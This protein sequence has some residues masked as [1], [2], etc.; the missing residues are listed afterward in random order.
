MSI[1]LHLNNKNTKKTHPNKP[2]I[3]YV[4][5][6]YDTKRAN[7]KESQVMTKSMSARVCAEYKK[8][9]CYMI[10]RICIIHMRLTISPQKFK[11][12]IRYDIP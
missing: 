5:V 9:C 10:M 4:T 8:N 6:C 7:H 1:L 12:I 2:M 3:Q 11:N